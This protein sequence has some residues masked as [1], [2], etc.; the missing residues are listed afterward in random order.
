MDVRK[1]HEPLILW[2]DY[3]ENEFPKYDNYDAIE[4]AKVS[5]IPKD[6]YSVM[7]VPITFLT[8]YCPEQFEIIGG[9]NGYKECDYESALLCGTRTEY[10]DK[11]GKVK[12]WTGPTVNKKTIYFRILIKRKPTIDDMI[13]YFINFIEDDLFTYGYDLQQI[14]SSLV[15]NLYCEE[16]DFPDII[17]WN[18]IGQDVIELC[19]ADLL[20]G[21]SSEIFEDDILAKKAAENAVQEFK[22]E[23]DSDG[24]LNWERIIK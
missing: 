14:R 22:W 15:E 6:Y 12:T 17:E 24:I 8:K 16:E 21:I 1:R 11:S 7:G 23:Y 4:V 10:V 19:V 18:L 20:V 9:F 3:R 13:N 5:N 2:K